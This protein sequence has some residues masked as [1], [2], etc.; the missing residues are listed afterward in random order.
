MIALLDV[1]YFEDDSARAACVVI[2]DFPCDTISEQRVV[3]V[4]NVEPYLSGQ[5]YRRE[6]P[7]LLA[8]L[9]EMESSIDCMVV[10]SYVDLPEGKGM[11]RRLFES[12]DENVPVVGVAKTKFQNA[13]S[14]CVLRGES[15]RPLFV[16]AA[17]MDTEEAGEKIESMHGE[18]RIPDMIRLVDQ[19]ARVN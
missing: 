6:L 19:L 17:G 15:E 7:C 1:H 10:D 11:G 5:F 9:E 2:E 16:S 3:Q 14:R 4:Q 13:E 18:F 12:F 8:V